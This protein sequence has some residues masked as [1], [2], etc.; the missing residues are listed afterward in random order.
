MRINTRRGFREELQR[1]WRDAGV[2]YPFLPVPMAEGLREE[3]CGDHHAARYIFQEL[4]A[5]FLDT[6]TDVEIY[7]VFPLQNYTLESLF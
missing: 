5:E 1:R 3:A 2:R 7:N 4:R 6:A